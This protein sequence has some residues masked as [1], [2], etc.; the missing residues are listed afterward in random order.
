MLTYNFERFVA[1][2]IESVLAQ[3][4]PAERLQLVVVDN[5]ST[6]GSR[7]LLQSYADRVELHLIDNI[8]VNAAVDFYLSLAKGEYL[9]CASGDDLWPADKVLRQARFLDEHPDVGLVYGDMETIDGEGNVLSDSFLATSSLAPENGRLL[10]RLMRGNAISGGSA[11]FR[12]PLLPAIRPIPPQ[13]SWED[14]WIATCVSRVA[15]IRFMPAITYRYR[16]HGA[17]LAFGA[18]GE[19]L[20][21]AHLEEVRFRRWLLETVSPGEVTLEDLRTAVR[22]L[23][24]VIEQGAQLAGAP[25]TQ[26]AP[27]DADDRIRAAQARRRAEAEADP[28]R[29]AF[30]HAASVA[31]DPLDPDAVAAFEACADAVLQQGVG[32]VVRPVDPAALLA[33]ARS[34]VVVAMADEVVADPSLLRPYAEA[35]DPADDATLVLYA[36]GWDDARAASELGAAL[37]SAGLDGEGAPDMLALPLED[38][39]SVRCALAVRAGGLLTARSAEWPLAGLPRFEPVRAAVTA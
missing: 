29:A 5:G 39:L 8:P 10:G 27:V 30:A 15:P 23:L 19:R 16:K 26:F 7:E 1:D 32:P 28:G 18:Q 34:R 3:D 22:A 12:R 25:R 24:D 11:M 17:N 13:A 21:R 6:D 20:H 4:W 38:S 37:S 33:D 2:A 14:W 36:P 31:A 35:T 9:A